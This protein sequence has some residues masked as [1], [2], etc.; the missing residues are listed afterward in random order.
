[1]IGALTIAGSD[2]SGGAGIQAD[3]RTF[4]A[5]GVLGYSAVTAITA[6]DHNYVSAV[7]PVNPDVVAHQIQV[8]LDSLKPA[9]VKTG[10]LATVAIVEAVAEVLTGTGLP[11]VIDP[12][13]SSTGG[14]SLLESGGLEAMVERL[15]PL[16]SVVTPNLKEAA[17]LL[18]RDLD[19]RE[20]DRDAAI[21]L[22]SRFGCWVLLKGGHLTGPATDL[23]TDG[24]RIMEFSQLR[25]PG[26]DVHGTG[27]VLSAAIAA[28]LAGGVRLDVAVGKAK[29]F[30]TAAISAA[31][32]RR[33]AP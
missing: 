24:L 26:P 20:P 5:H 33:P 9:A 32:E 17:M 21:A 10:M 16:A 15:V 18:G 31:N 2:P 22:A 19:T 6:Q 8:V 29:E 4:A 7:H 13:F 14:V 23:L 11:L 30:V 12:V 25:V 27:C 28:N 1:M 3:L